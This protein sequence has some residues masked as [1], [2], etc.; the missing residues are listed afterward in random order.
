MT[1]RQAYDQCVGQLAELKLRFENN[2]ST[3]GD[4]IAVK[5]KINVMKVRGRNSSFFIIVLWFSTLVA[6]KI[7]DYAKTVVGRKVAL[8]FVGT[9]TNRVQRSRDCGLNF[10]ICG[11]PLHPGIALCNVRRTKPLYARQEQL[12]GV[13][14]RVTCLNRCANSSFISE[15]YAHNLEAYFSSTA[16]WLTTWYLVKRKGLVP[17]WRKNVELMHW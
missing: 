17:A 2:C 13:D 11:V 15:Q 10:V 3:D 12:T 7:Y 16:G 1:Y 6:R 4:L 8:N 9:W 5:Q 14:W